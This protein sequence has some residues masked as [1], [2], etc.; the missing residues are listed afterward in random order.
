MRMVV[1]LSALALMPVAGLG[2]IG[3]ELEDP[4]LTGFSQTEARSWKELATGRLVLL[5]FFAHW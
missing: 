3:Q 5:E 4:G 2:Q 1:L